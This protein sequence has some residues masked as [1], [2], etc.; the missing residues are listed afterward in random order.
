MSLN[1]F[2]EIA[3]EEAV[4]MREAG[5]VGQVVLLSIGDKR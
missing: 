5:H 1:P 3:I 4:K 2:D